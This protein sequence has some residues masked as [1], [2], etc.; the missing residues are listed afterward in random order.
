MPYYYRRRYRPWR[1]RRWS[2][3]S[4]FRGPFRRRLS[5]RRVRKP[6]RKLKTLTV[7]EW[8]PRVIK[9]CNI[10]GMLCLCAVNKERLAN[11]YIMYES[12][13][14]PEH[15]PGNGGFSVIK[16]SLETLYSM[17]EQCRNWWTVGNDNLPICRYLGTTI[18][19][20]QSEHVDIVLRYDNTYPMVSGPLTYPSCQPSISAM[21]PQSII[22]PG[23]R[24][25]KLRKTYIK[26]RI[27]PPPQLKT[28]WYFQKEFF[29]VPLFVLY[30]TP[31]SLDHYYISTQ[32]SSNSITIET[33]N[34][35]LFQNRNFA[36]I[37]TTGYSLSTNGTVQTYLYATDVEGQ[38]H[39]DELI[40]LA[41]TKLYK[42]GQA[43][44]ELTGVTWDTYKNSTN[45]WGNPFYKDYL[46]G[47]VHLYTAEKDPKSF[48]SQFST[49]HE[50]TNTNQLKKLNEPLRFG[51]RYN[52]Y[53]DTGKS[54]T[55]NLNKVYLLPNNKQG[56][57]WDPPT[58][59]DLILEG[60]PLWIALFG[61]VDFEKKL[62][63]ITGIDSNYMVVIDTK[64]LSPP[65]HKPIVLIDNSFIQGHSP[66]ISGV[67]ETD[68][69]KWYPQTQFQQESINNIVHSGPG[70]CKLEGQKS[71]EIK[72]KYSVHFKF[73]GNPAKIHTVENPADQPVYPIPRD[74]F[75]TTSLQNPTQPIEY[76]L[77]QFDERRGLITG[78]AAKR[79]KKDS[80]IKDTLL[81]ITGTAKEVPVQTQE[82]SEEE[83][84]SEKEEDTLLH[85][86]QQQLIRQRKFKRRILK[87]M[88]PNLE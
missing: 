53:K 38:P 14:T 27:P 83:T 41:N 78:P 77:Q 10:K 54:N 6:K 80:D 32:A 45:Y 13:I 26:I 43:F 82:T 61:F 18:T 42:P 30:T 25:Q 63:K 9:S 24:T 60:F 33:I 16:F 73:G 11:N 72:C 7:K 40:P 15:Q 44:T 20:Y 5:R 86:L 51:F 48:F 58:D 31:T 64:S 68:K 39:A 29:K 17:H 1:Y 59:T 21:L 22:I 71:A 55:G 3:R 36:T 88:S 56:Q 87:L 79:L 66:Y 4:W 19:V 84:D 2:R 12:S 67:H 34:T 50:I 76:Y 49:N 35:T 47:D 65:Y 74:Q 23:K 70:T 37:P 75:Q 85:Q 46:T 8:Q 62:Q 81:S 28:Q 69:E 57:G 52:P